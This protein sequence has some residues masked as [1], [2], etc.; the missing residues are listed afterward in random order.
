MNLSDRMDFDHVIRVHE[1]G[2]VTDEPGIYAP[3]MLLDGEISDSDWEFFST[4]Y[5]GQYGYNGPI[6]HNS[7][8]I[9]GRLERDIL[10]TPGV[11]VAV[12]ANWTPEDEAEK[13]MEDY[14][15]EGWAILKLK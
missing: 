14:Y 10:E 2:T 7:E 8:F 6:M 9:G 15:A 4:G 11:Y 13:E 5:T 12:I 3:E 1:D